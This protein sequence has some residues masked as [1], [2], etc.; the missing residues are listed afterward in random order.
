MRGKPSFIH[1]K[2]WECTNNIKTCSTRIR[3]FQGSRVLAEFKSSHPDIHLLNLNPYTKDLCTSD[4]DPLIALSTDHYCNQ[5]NHLLQ[6]PVI[7]FSIHGPQL[8]PEVQLDINLSTPTTT[9]LY[10]GVFLEARI[11]ANMGSVYV[12][13]ASAAEPM[14]TGICEGVNEV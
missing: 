8:D 9:A 5:T 2:F 3:A 11:K 7:Y 1:T 4:I 12:A 14:E 6:K 13:G 10:E